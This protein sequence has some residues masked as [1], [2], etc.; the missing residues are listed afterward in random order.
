MNTVIIAQILGIF[1]VIAGVSMLANKKGTVV[2]IEE[3]VQNKGTLWLWGF[4]AI[5]I[6]ATIVVQN[7]V[8]TSGLPLLVTILG[9]LALIKGAFILFFPAAAT[10]L[11]KKCN[12]GNL[13][14]LCG[15]VMLVL[16]LVLLYW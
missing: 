3:S 1:F 13:L 15:L 9:W 6:G 4:L 7:N 16:G 14:V 11:Y 12:K 8:W 2:A 5:L 10:A